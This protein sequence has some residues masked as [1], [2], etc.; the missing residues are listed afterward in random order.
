MPTLPHSP[1]VLVCFGAKKLEGGLT[2]SDHFFAHATVGL[3]FE[4][5]TLTELTGRRLPAVIIVELFVPWSVVPSSKGFIPR[6][7]VVI[8]PVCLRHRRQAPDTGKLGSPLTGPCTRRGH[9]RLGKRTT[10][11]GFGTKPDAFT[12]TGTSKKALWQGINPNVTACAAPSTIIPAW[13]SCHQ[14]HTQ[15]CLRRP[16][17]VF[18]ETTEQSSVR[19]AGLRLHMGEGITPHSHRRTQQ[20]T[21]RW[22]H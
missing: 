16:D 20:A 6:P 19:N 5:P 1:H 21:S 22:I 18:L 8:P 13:I 12:C 3:H 7:G 4:A 10:F 11:G 2:E 15:V 17:S 9:L 14:Q